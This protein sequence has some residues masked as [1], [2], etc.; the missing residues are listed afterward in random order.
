MLC[1]QEPETINHLLVSCVF[2]RIFWYF[3]LRLLGLEQ[4]CPQPGENS[5][6]DW[7]RRSAD[8]MQD[9]VRKGA[10]SLVILGSWT[11]WKHRNHCVFDGAS[12][13]LGA[14]LTTAQQDAS[15]W[16]L[17]GTSGINFLTAP[18]EGG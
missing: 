3:H 5:F 1:D 9:Q 4:L 2:S 15:L 17:A 14:A 7:C 10:N 18:L 12:P 8:A 11:L 13:Y 16:S 6:D